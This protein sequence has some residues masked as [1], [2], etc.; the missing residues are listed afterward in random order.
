LTGAVVK[1]WKIALTVSQVLLLSLVLA[2]MYRMLYMGWPREN[3]DEIRARIDS[4]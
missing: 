3:V 1:S 4:P 2:A